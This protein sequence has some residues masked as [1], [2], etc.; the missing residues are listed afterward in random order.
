M[1]CAVTETDVG[2]VSRVKYHL[3]DGTALLG[4]YV[5]RENGGG[6]LQKNFKNGE[7]RYACNISAGRRCRASAAASSLL[8]KGLLRISA[9]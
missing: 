1:H 2:V 5:N 3:G 6:A 4:L 8:T 7:L 9:V